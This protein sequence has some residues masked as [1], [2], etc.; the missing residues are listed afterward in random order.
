MKKA[1]LLVL[2]ASLASCTTMRQAIPPGYSGSVATIQESAIRVDRGKAQMFYL[3]EIDGVYLKE[4]CGQRS[5]V[6]SY[7]RGNNLTIVDSPYE[8]PA[9]LHTY[10][11]EGSNVWAMDARGLV[12]ADLTVTGETTFKPVEG[13]T[14]LIN[15]SLSKEESVV[16]LKDAITGAV[17]AEFRKKDP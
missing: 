5:Y 13:R 4:N 3:K 8:I 15:G 10:T 7:G 1:L 2:I 14:Y 9:E 12:E 16:W 17:I 6:Q 11:I